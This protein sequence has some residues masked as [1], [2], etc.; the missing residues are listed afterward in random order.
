MDLWRKTMMRLI[1]SI[2]GS[3][4]HL[5]RQAYKLGVVNGYQLAKAKTADSEAQLEIRARFESEC[6]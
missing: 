4:C 5:A 1:S 2:K 3:R 6:G